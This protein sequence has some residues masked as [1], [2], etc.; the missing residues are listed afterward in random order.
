MDAQFVFAFLMLEVL[1]VP[2]VNVIV[3][4]GTYKPVI[5][6]EFN[7]AIYSIITLCL[8][9][10]IWAVFTNGGKDKIMGL[11]NFCY[12]LGL[13]VAIGFKITKLHNFRL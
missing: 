2:G 7:N 13:A 11:T 8:I 4:I 9:T 12:I 6:A 3:F 1:L 10:T 5:H